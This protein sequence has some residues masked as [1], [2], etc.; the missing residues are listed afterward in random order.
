[1][2]QTLKR[3]NRFHHLKIHHK[4]IAKL[5][6]KERSKRNSTLNVLNISE[7]VNVDCSQ[8]IMMAYASIANSVSSVAGRNNT[9]NTYILKKSIFKLLRKTLKLIEH[10]KN[11]QVYSSQRKKRKSARNVG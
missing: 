5:F 10:V 11:A 2:N 4:M 7:S 3:G 1:M 8:T 6:H 9:V